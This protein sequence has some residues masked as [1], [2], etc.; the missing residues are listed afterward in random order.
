MMSVHASS[1]SILSTWFSRVPVHLVLAAMVPVLILLAGNIDQIGPG[2]ATRAFLFSIG[3]G[4]FAVLL[5][6]LILSDW[7]KIAVISTV[8]ILLFFSYGHA[9]DY[10]RESWDF[11]RT[12]ARH[13]YMVPLWLLVL[14]ASLYAIR[15]FRAEV[16]ALTR[17]LNMAVLVMAVIPFG[18]ILSHEVRSNL[19]ASSLE[20]LNASLRANCSRIKG[21]CQTSTTLFSIRIAVTIICKRS[22]AMTIVHFSTG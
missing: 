4:L 11:G 19:A 3:A 9:Y 15:R 20:E 13:R 14:A 10:V 5:F 17:V 12:V 1:G 8:V 16:G 6:R 2:A 22:L 18:R 7:R 21:R